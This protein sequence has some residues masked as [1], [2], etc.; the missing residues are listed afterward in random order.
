M[1][2]KKKKNLPKEWDERDNNPDLRKLHF[3]LL[4]VHMQGLVYYFMKCIIA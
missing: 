3:I 2:K 4:K 1:I